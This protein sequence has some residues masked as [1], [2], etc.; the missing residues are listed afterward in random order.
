MSNIIDFIN[1]EYTPALFNRVREIFPAMEFQPYKGGWSSRFKLDGTLPH[2]PRRDKSVITSHI[3]HGIIEQG[4]DWVTLTE[5][6]RM[7]NGLRNTKEARAAICSQLGLTM[8]EGEESES[9]KAYKEKQDRLEALAKEMQKAL[10]QE[11]GKGV[12]SYLR[13]GR[14]YS[15]EFIEWSGFGYCSPQMADKLRPLF[16]YTTTAGEKNYLPKSAGKEHTMVLPY[17]SE[18]GSINGFI[19]RATDASVTDGKYQKAYIEEVD[20]KVGTSR[21]ASQKLH[22]FGLTHLTPIAGDDWHKLVI[23]VE[24]EIDAL[25][26]KYET[27]IPNIVASGGMSISEEVI[28][29]AKR[30]GATGILLLFD[31]ECN[32]PQNPKK[33]AQTAKAIETAIAAIE[34][35]GLTAYIAELPLEDGA[36]KTDVDSYLKH[37]TGEQLEKEVLLLKTKAPVWKFRRL[38][39][40]LRE[41]YPDGEA[42]EDIIDEHRRRTISLINECKLPSDKEIIA[43]KFFDVWQEPY[44]IT[45]EAILEEADRLKGI[46]DKRHQK[47]RLKDVL[48]QVYQL[49][50]SEDEEGTNKGMELLQKEL[51]DIQGISRDVEFSR[52]LS[53]PTAEGIRQSLQNRPTGIPTRY[54]FGEGDR[55]EPFILPA[56]ALTYICAPTSHGKS[57]MQQNLA[58]DVATDGGE[59]SVLYFSFEEARED[60]IM[61]FLNI[62]VNET[63]TARTSHS[64]NLRTITEYYRDGSTKYIRQNILPKFRQEEQGFMELLHSG[65]LR[66]FH[67]NM[68]STA[69]IECV[70]FMA[71]HIKV[72]AVFIDYIQRLR[73]KGSRLQRKDLL[74][75]ICD[76]LMTLSI[77]IQVPVVLVAQLNREALSPTEMAAQ[78][79][80]EAS[81]I[82]H[83]ANIVMLL[84]NSN[85]NPLPKS[86]YFLST[87]TT[88]KGDDKR[89]ERTPSPEAQRLMAKGF[90]IGEEGK[91]YAVLAKN[92]GGYRNIDAVLEFDGNT[93]RI[94]QNPLATQN[95]HGGNSDNYGNLWSGD[96]L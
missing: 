74:Q 71:K 92:R 89:T 4:G 41:L 91:L 57:T 66:V 36:V 95:Q 80:A 55:Q 43:L 61:K 25:R 18:G 90:N 3:P 9:Y 59:G 28:K 32:T 96:M 13:D 76:E 60:V 46:A 85:T 62:Y 17:R 75:E 48:S 79:I 26:A 24:G 82:E 37:H 31:R 58:L 84:W 69:L 2:T 73:K 72:R 21:K 67:E 20:Y 94:T 63:L 86:S 8:P 19:F 83:S 7:Q 14:G 42:P 11:E 47:A 22:L 1:N 23:I 40:E 10:Y 5:L 45:E 15:D 52:L 64:N 12:L 34:R 81:D 16:T 35:H 29:E 50:D 93:G 27:G 54:T 51:P 39:D 33:E 88:G 77:D 38:V 56:G 68:D 6:Y 53:L 30:M 44:K 87:K 70:R 78:N 65:K 49:V